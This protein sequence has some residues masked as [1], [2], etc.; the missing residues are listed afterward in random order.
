MLESEKKV[1]HFQNKAA[2]NSVSISIAQV[3]SVSGSS[4]VFLRDDS[5][6]NCFPESEEAAAA[7][8][9]GG[10]ATSSAAQQ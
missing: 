4:D 8:R 3:S 9:D 7:G 5:I 1:F 6:R 2:G 10:A